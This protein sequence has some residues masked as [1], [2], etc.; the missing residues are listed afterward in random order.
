[1]YPTYSIFFLSKSNILPSYLLHLLQN[2]SQKLT[3]EL[4]EKPA[5]CDLIII[6]TETTSIDT[7]SKSTKNKPFLLFTFKLKPWIIQYTHY[8]ENNGII[9]ANMNPKDIY[10]TVMASLN[11]DVNYNEELLGMLFSKKINTLASKVRSLTKREN[12]IIRLMIKDLTNEEISEKLSLSI[13]TVNTHKRNIMKKIGT[14]TISG[15]LKIV[16]DYSPHLKTLF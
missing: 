14:K 13:R 15:M 6:D 8:L 16:I 7:A 10:K 4:A 12:E 3:I 2:V 11:G 9:Y 1:M 5:D